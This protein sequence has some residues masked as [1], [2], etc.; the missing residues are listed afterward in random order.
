MRGPSYQGGTPFYTPAHKQREQIQKK[1][2]IAWTKV[3]VYFAKLG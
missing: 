1:I 3:L 2:L